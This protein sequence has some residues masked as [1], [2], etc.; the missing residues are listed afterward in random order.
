MTI[1]VTNEILIKNQRKMRTT[2]FITGLALLFILFI[3][4][5]EES[6][7]IEQS[8]MSNKECIKC[9]ENKLVVVWSS[10]DPMVA[11]RVALMYPHAAQGNKWFDEVT[12]VIWGPSAKLIADDVE[13][14]NKIAQMKKDGV[15]IKA[16]IA[17]A[18]E[19]GVADKLKALGYEVIP[20]GAPLTDY[21]KSGYKVLTF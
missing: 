2:K 16:C 17:C 18:N 5:Y 12:L 11:K 14:Q 1:I 10:D 8:C 6:Y 15:V 4:P 21:L 20:M 19:Y 9:N 13:L 7:A 3:L